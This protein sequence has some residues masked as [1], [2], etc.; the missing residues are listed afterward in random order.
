MGRHVQ[1]AAWALMV[2]VF[3]FLIA[4]SLGES[5]A[6]AAATHGLRPMVR[7]YRAAPP[8][9]GLPAS[10]HEVPSLR[11]IEYRSVSKKLSHMNNR[12]D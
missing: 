11:R 1:A 8:P 2:S 4:A 6:R 3:A 7:A 12:L 9:R 10:A 5:G